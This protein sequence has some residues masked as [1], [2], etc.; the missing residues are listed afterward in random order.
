VNFRYG[1]YPMHLSIVAGMSSDTVDAPANAAT[2]HDGIVVERSE[3]VV[4][5]TL[6]RPRKKNAVNQA[7]W[8]ELEH[9]LGR[10]RYSSD[11]RAVVLTGAGGDFCS[12]ADVSDM[13]GGSDQHTLAQ[14]RQVGNIVLLLQRLPQPTIAK[15][16]GV[17]A[18]IG[19]NMALMCDLV[20]AADGARF[21]EIFARRGLTVDGGGSWILPRAVGIHRAKEM[22][23]LA[24]MIDST[25]AAEM[26]LVNR[27]LPD[28]ELDAFVDAWAGRLAAGPPIAQAMAKRLVNNSF[29]MTLEQ[30]LDEEGLSQ[31]VNFGTKDT[32]EAVMAFLEKRQPEFRGR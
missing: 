17:A 25:Q 4:T 11:D 19:L 23:L 7:M 28:D 26:G 2:D 32:R 9:E 13:Q 10:I 8:E 14:M 6:N 1:L 15:V 16:R 3:G 31:T 24:D 20:V 27:V 22:I 12:G 21:S 29:D 5:V 30:A 18:G